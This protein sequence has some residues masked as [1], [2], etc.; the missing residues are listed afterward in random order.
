MKDLAII[1]AGGFGREVALLID[2]INQDKKHWNLIG[3]FD[4]GDNNKF[5]LPILGKIEKIST[6]NTALHVA[7]AIAD[8]VVRKSVVARV[9]THKVDFPLIC[10]PKANKGAAVNSFG[11]GT[12]ITEG[13]ILTS[14]I[15]IG[16]FVIINLCTT[17]GHDAVVGDFSSI[18]PGSNISGNVKIGA[19]TLIGTGA[20]ILQNLVIGERARVGAGAVVTRNVNSSE[21][22][23]GIPA[24]PI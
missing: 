1:G 22:V 23:V 10:H 4:D 18:M 17:I 13:V 7:V 15:S 21:T 24:K 20:K 14:G 5:A 2:Q 6:I 12:I 3:F 16:Q 19:E 9:P 11:R 8:P